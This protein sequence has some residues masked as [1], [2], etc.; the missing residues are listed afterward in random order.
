MDL[1]SH[2]VSGCI[3][4]YLCACAYVCIFIHLNVLLIQVIVYVSNIDLL[5]LSIDVV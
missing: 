1:I 4:L 2:C 5:L 3:A